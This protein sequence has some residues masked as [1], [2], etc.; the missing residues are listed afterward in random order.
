MKMFTLQTKY[1]TNLQTMNK[2]IK[3]L[4]FKQ[5]Y[6]QLSKS[7]KKA[8]RNNFLLHFEYEYSTFYQK[9]REMSFKKVELEY[10][11]N[12]LPATNQNIKLKKD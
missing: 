3:E 1:K 12:Q 5:R 7:D 2:E 4:T 9:L 10:L 11:E 8:I 6:D